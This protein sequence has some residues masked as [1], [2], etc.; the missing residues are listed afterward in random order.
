MTVLIAAAGW[1][2]AYRNAARL[3][4]KNAES[5]RERQ[6]RAARLERVNRQ[7][8]EL[9]GPLLAISLAGTSAWKS[10]GNMYMRPDVWSMADATPDELARFRL[11]MQVVQMPLNERLVEVITTKADLLEGD[12]V[13]QVLLDLCAH[14]FS[15]KGVMARWA[16]D[17]FSRHFTALKFPGAELNGYATT[18]YRA[19]KEE[20]QRLIGQQ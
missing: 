11:W 9:Y 3:A 15:Y 8:S 14:V 10:F 17:D 18:N 12:D 5:D 13:P 1:A 7:L 4:D 19:L 16:L 20:Q 6:Q 2:A